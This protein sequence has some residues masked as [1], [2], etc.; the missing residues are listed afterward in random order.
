MYFMQALLLTNR[1]TIHQDFSLKKPTFI[2]MLYYVEF[3][4]FCVCRGR[5]III[6][7]FAQHLKLHNH[8]CKR[9]GFTH[10]LV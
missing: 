10:A 8:V 7:I 9:T 2:Q 6:P 1:T 3:V 4:N 5:V